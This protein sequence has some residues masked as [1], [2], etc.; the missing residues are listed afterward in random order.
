MNKVER[1]REYTRK[2]EMYLT[3][4]NSR[5]DCC[6]GFNTTQCFMIVEIGRA[7]G[8]SVKE[9]ASLLRMDKGGVSRTVDKLVCEGYVERKSSKE[10]RRWIE[11]SL[12]RE[13]QAYFEK[14]EKDMNFKFKEILSEIPKEKQ[15]QVLEALQLYVIAC[16]KAEGRKDDSGNETC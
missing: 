6:C 2:L 13:G 11:L 8:I 12:T 10:D 3:N 7:P 16:Q 9:L 1:F 14:I 5:N 4:I 15:E